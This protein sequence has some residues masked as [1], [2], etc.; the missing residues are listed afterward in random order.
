MKSYSKFRVFLTMVLALLITMSSLYNP[1]IANA[2][3]N[4]VLR[5]ENPNDTISINE[6]DSYSLP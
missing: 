5:V 2:N 1:L 4:E 6:G 3:G